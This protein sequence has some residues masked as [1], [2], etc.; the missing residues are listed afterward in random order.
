MAKSVC[1][2]LTKGA[3]PTKAGKPQWGIGK[4]SNNVEERI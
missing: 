2:T 3:E 1:A 4:P